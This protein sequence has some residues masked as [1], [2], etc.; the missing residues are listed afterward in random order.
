[1]GDSN[2]TIIYEHTRDN[3]AANRHQYSGEANSWF[4][5]GRNGT[6]NPPAYGSENAGA[7][8]AGRIASSSK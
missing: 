8:E 1:M 6:A 4:D 5:H 7:Y 3:I 2:E